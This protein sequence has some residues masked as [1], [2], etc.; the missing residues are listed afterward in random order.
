MH[1]F[2]LS[3]VA[4][5]A[6]ISVTEPCKAA[7]SYGSLGS[8][9]TENFDGLPTDMPGSTSS[10]ESVY[11][12][13]WQDDVNYLTSAED[14]VSV[15]G[16]HLYHPLSPSTENGFNG[17]QRF[18]NGTGGNTGAFW[19]FGNFTSAS[20]KALGSLGSSTVAANGANMYMG[21]QLI[22]ATGVTLSSFTFTYYGEQWR[23]GQGT[24]GE[25]LTAAYSLSATDADWYSSSD[26][27]ALPSL[28][29]T[30]PV[31][32]GT[33]SS[34]TAVD[35]NVAGRSGPLTATVSGIN[36]LP[37]AEL[38]IRFADPQLASLADDGLAIDDLSFSAVPEAS[39]FLLFGLV[40]SAA[41]LGRV[42][43]KRK[44]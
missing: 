33:N 9:Y 39:S 25:T 7:I 18:R 13:G 27:T 21:L 2:C 41:G 31:F 40:A 44:P 26:F 24:T 36:W 35:G 16:W 19:S 20:E 34:G 43:R 8:T 17:N 4:L 22:N 29:F 28:S 32:A 38:W 12:D 42:L 5:V 23:D 3:W 15:L 6:A 10:I 11:Q 14:D 30:S 37:G 1:R